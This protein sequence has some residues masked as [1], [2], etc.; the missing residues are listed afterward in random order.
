MM[1][2]IVAFPDLEEPTRAVNWW[3]SNFKVRFFRT[4]TS[5]R[6]GMRS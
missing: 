4:G 6:N 5:E 2:A 3:A 1:A